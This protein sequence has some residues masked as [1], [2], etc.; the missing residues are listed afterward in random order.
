MENE[1]PEREDPRGAHITYTVDS[2]D[3]GIVFGQHKLNPGQ[4]PRDYYALRI[5]EDG[6]LVRLRSRYSLHQENPFHELEKHLMRLSS[7]G[8]LRSSA[9]YF[10]V[11]TD[12]F[13]PFQGKFDATMKFLKLFER[14]TPGV[15]VVQTRSPLV[16]LAMPVLKSL[17]AH[18]AVTL[19]IETP[20]ETAAQRYTPHL[21]R[22]EERIKAAAALRRFGIEVTLQVSP[23]LPYG[24]W[25]KDAGSFAEMLSE[26][27]DYV[28]VKALS[29]GS[30]RVERRVRSTSI[31]KKLAEDRQF[32]YLRPDTAKPLLNAL[33]A[34]K[35]E[36]LRAPVRPQLKPRQMSMFAA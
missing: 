27:A 21:P 12:P 9:I 35:P 16:V 20:L 14:Y 36:A 2:F 1:R 23:V 34:M 8:I 13:L 29:D 5:Q 7:Q 32:Y 24:D 10:G 3:D 15:L 26:N 31:A 19:G 18:A 28:H 6:D 25:K 30:E 4:D 17:G 33:D 11:S 22:A